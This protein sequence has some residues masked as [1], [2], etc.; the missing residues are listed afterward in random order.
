ME[1]RAYIHKKKFHS[2]IPFKNI[3]K[4]NKILIEDVLQNMTST[5]FSTQKSHLFQLVIVPRKYV[6]IA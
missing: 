2:F 4:K 1:K 3:Q 5:W 6:P